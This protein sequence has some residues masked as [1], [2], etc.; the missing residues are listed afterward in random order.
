MEYTIYKNRG[1]NLPT[2]TQIAGPSAII[3]AD[4]WAEAKREFKIMVRNWSEYSN[5]S[6]TGSDI[7]TVRLDDTN[8]YIFKK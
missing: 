2:R 5:E 6:F 3:F 1:N 7:Y 8:Y 4:S